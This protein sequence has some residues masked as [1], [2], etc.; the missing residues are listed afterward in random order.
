MD[1]QTNVSPATVALPASSMH[2]QKLGLPSPMHHSHTHHP[3]QHHQNTFS[4]I[5]VQIECEAG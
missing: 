3:H 2:A 5:Q 4:Y 1:P